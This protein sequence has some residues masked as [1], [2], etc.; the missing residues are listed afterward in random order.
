MTITTTKLV[1]DNL[2]IITNSNGIGGEFQQKLVDVV[3]SNNAS[4]EP[5]VSIANMQYEILGTGNVTVFFKNDTEKKVIISGRGNWGLKPDEIKI[6][7][8]IGDIFLNSDDTIT[9]YNL[10]IETQKEAGYK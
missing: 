7:D 4:S 5:K 3:G 8:P 2:K 9:K 1:D 10:V 6:Q